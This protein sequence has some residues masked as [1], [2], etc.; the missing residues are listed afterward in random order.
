[1]KDEDRKLLTEFLGECWHEMTDEIPEQR[2]G[3][4]YCPKCNM[5]FGAIHCSDWSGGEAFY[6]KFTTPDDMMAV[7]E[8]LVKK[9][10]WEEFI[11]CCVK[12][13]NYMPDDANYYYARL[14][15]Y[16][17]NPTRFCQLA[18]DFLKE[19]S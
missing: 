3:Y 8:K 14:Y 10:L 1:M 16:L 12:K 4:L 2:L 19:S 7:K 6:R 18:V 9:G 15:G 11:L 5:S 13:I 17:I